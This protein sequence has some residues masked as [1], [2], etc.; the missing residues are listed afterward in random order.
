MAETALQTEVVLRW[1]SFLPQRG[2]CNC[3]AVQEKFRAGPQIF[4]ISGLIRSLAATG[5][6]KVPEEI[7][8]PIIEIQAIWRASRTY[9]AKIAI[10]PLA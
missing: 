2:L 6:F 4:L 9:F 5:M 1:G 7:T 10:A 3:C 8:K